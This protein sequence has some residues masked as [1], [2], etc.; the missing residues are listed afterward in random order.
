MS[1]VSEAAR[2][3]WADIA[4]SI[5]LGNPRMGQERIQAA[6]DAEVLTVGKALI[7]DRAQEQNRLLKIIAEADQRVSILERRLCEALSGSS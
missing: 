1:K 3:A 4:G 2:A 6:I 5:G 7:A